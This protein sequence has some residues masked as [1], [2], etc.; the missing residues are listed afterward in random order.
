MEPRIQRLIERG[1]RD[2]GLAYLVLALVAA[3]ALYAPTLGRGL[4]NY[5]DPWLYTNNAVLHHPSWAG[6]ATV[7]TD[8]DSA[9]RYQLSP[10]YLP[11]RDL[12]V[13]A[14]YAIWG[15]HYGGFHLTSL[16]VYLA[17]IAIWFAA[18]CELGIPRPIAG[19]AL[20]IWAVHPSHAESVAWLAERKGVLGMMWSGTCAL[21]YA[22][23][24]AGRS[25]WWLVLAVTGG[26]FAV[27]SKAIAAFAVAALGPLELALPARRVSWRRSLLGLGAIAT[28][29]G[30]AYAPVVALAVRWSIVGGA[31]APLPAS[32]LVSV[33]GVHGF[34]LRL[35]AATIANAVS[36]PIATAGPSALDLGLGALG[37]AAVI[38]ALVRGS[39]VVRA[40]AIVWLFGWLP[41][42]HLLLPLQM[43][44]VAD[45][46]LL[47]PSLGFALAVAVGL[48]AIGRPGLRRIAIG[49]VVAA[50]VLRALAAQAAWRSNEALW[51]RAIAA[52]PDDGNAWAMY[53]EALDADGRPDEAARV[54]D[55]ALAH[56]RL[57]RLVLHAG[58][59]ALREGRTDAAFALFREAATRGDP[60]AMANYA[61]Q[62]AARGQLAEALRWARY[63]TTADPIYPNSHRIRGKIARLVDQHSPESLHA[64]ERAYQL[65]PDVAIDRYNLGIAYADAGRTAEARALLESCVADRGV[66]E[67][68]RRAL[69]HL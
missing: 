56:S 33:L 48:A 21:G 43:V 15:E 10:E 42:G 19:L 53:L 16:L 45:R 3:V 46:Y 24:R 9:Q 5:D 58:L 38:A 34:Y 61:N 54:I 26:V 67:L 40:A 18:L 13:M 27:W 23:Y 28:C 2:P 12:S 41:V 63:A 32:R 60:R 37:F 8:L 55:D 47:V 7:F 66:G 20:L 52:N 30:L 59:V 14:D 68:A 44:F 62:L 31:S 51:Q 6:V 39:P 22:R 4:V 64:F 29:T 36:Y 49:A 1:R 69:A 65:E 35:A 57:P 25:A 50:L 11:I 17:A